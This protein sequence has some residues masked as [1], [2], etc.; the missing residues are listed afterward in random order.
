MMNE[1]HTIAA[2]PHPGGRSILSFSSIYDGIDADEY[3]EWESKIDNIF[4]QYRMYEWRNIKN[5]SSVL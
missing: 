5:A 1:T 3:I 4:T 2:T